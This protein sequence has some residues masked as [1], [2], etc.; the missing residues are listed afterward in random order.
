M[1]ACVYARAHAGSSVQHLLNQ[2]KAP[3]LLRSGSRFLMTTK[4]LLPLQFVEFCQNHHMP[5]FILTMET[6]TL[7]NHQPNLSEFLNGNTEVWLTTWEGVG[8]GNTTDILCWQT[9]FQS[10]QKRRKGKDNH[11]YGDFIQAVRPRRRRCRNQREYEWN[12]S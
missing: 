2:P 10:E 1:C 5:F 6:L 4:V 9:F 8:G 12:S 7:K 3:C 11:R